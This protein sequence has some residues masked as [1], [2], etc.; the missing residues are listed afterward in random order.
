MTSPESVEK[1][2]DLEIISDPNTIK[3]L[4]EPTR[5]EIVFKY[6]INGSMTVKQL[7]DALDKNPGTILHHIDKLKEVGLVVQERTETT[8]T[9][10]VQR[11]YRATARDFR[12][13][14]TGMMQATGDVREFATG[15]LRSMISGLSVYGIEIPGSQIEKAMDL[16]R[17]L[18]EREN[19]VSSA[20][21]ITDQNRY[22]TLSES[23]R[24]DT[25]RIMRRFVLDEDSEYKRLR[26]EWDS[27]LRPYRKVS[28]K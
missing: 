10:I 15:R 23:V 14:L 21:V 4:M 9:G 27:L 1:M 2:K 25:S 24:N 11:F 13:G 5:A 17:R 22:S 19:A 20:L 28:K 26:E 6:L 8:S 3:V 12:L 16:L 7:S 18:I